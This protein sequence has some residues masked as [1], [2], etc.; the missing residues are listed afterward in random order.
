MGAKVD[1]FAPGEFCKRY[2][3]AFTQQVSKYNYYNSKTVTDVCHSK[4]FISYRKT[5]FAV[6]FKFGF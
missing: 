4:L 5:V 3:S 2:A 6:N 1:L